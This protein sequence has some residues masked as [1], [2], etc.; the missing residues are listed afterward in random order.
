MSSSI[1]DVS[2]EDISY[3]DKKLRE[4]YILREIGDEL[5]ISAKTVW[6]VMDKY[7]DKKCIQLMRK[8]MKV[9]QRIKDT[10]ERIREQARLMPEATLSEIGKAASVTRMDTRRIARIIGESE[11]Q[12]SRRKSSYI[13]TDMSDAELLDALKIVA[14][15]IGT[16]TLS[17]AQYSRNRV[18]DMPNSVTLTKRFGGWSNALEQAGL[19]RTYS[20]KRN[21][22]WSESDMVQSVTDFLLSGPERHTQDA[23]NEWRRTEGAPRPSIKSFKNRGWVWSQ[24]LSAAKERVGQDQVISG[25]L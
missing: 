6:S 21:Q 18:S 10:E 8:K 24:I 16:D 19:K 23:Y 12:L 25:Q 14:D 15:Q 5:G 13:D 2:A 9:Q 7:L 4:G 17:V 3:I 11:E 20:P 22:V 1:S